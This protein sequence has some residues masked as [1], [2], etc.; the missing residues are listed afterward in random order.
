[1]RG[2]QTMIEISGKLIIEWWCGWIRSSSASTDIDNGDCDCNESD[3]A[4][5]S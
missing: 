1:M 5:D 2:F 3:D 4:Y